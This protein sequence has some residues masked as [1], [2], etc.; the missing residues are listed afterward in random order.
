MAT[1]D[2]LSQLR[3]EIEGLKLKLRNEENARRKAQKDLKELQ[4]RY[5]RQRAKL[6]SK[7]GKVDGAEIEGIQVSCPNKDI[8]I[9]VI[10]K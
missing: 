2:Q 9:L 7:R 6:A 1:N 5:E 8:F 4:S 10:Q 3:L